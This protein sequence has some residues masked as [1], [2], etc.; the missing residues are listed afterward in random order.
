VLLG[1]TDSM[2]QITHTGG[3]V[4]SFIAG[5]S[6]RP[7]GRRRVVATVMLV[8]SALALA[9]CGDSSK[10]TD[11]PDA[12]S[13][14]VN[15][16]TAKTAVE[17]AYEGTYSSPPTTPTAPPADKNLWVISCGQ[18]AVGC[19]TPSDAAAEAAEAVGWDVTVYDGKLGADNAY[20]TGVRQ[21]V[22]AKADAIIIAAFDCAYAKAP[23]QE[24][25]DA[26]ILVVSLLAYDCDDPRVGG[27]DPL[28]TGS[29]IPNE[30]ETTVADYSIA[31]GKMKADWVIAQ[32][33]GDTTALSLNNTGVLL[34]QDIAK[35]FD[36]EIKACA[37]CKLVSMPFTLADIAGGALPGKVGQALLKDPDVNAAMVP[38]DALMALGVAQAFVR[39]GKN[40]KIATIGGEGYKPNL[41]LIES[42]GGQD[43]AV[44]ES[45]AWFGYAAVD[46]LIRLFNGEPL[47]PA[48]IGSQ[49][50]DA[51]H[52][53][54]TDEQGII[55]PV[56]FKAAYLKAWGK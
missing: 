29:V 34:G 56:D 20:S 10:A 54:P 5:P 11:G 30:N 12:A 50:V 28:F 2:P 6:A 35:G 33:D 51:D 42:N 41:D 37:S 22:A 24:A 26:G 8:L 17:A 3:I 45:T 36:D 47:E 13:G 23:L 15:L 1:P 16:E 9:G 39:S 44:Y 19:S 38:Y 14:S 7:N 18:V 21:A 48:G 55:A 52:V 31:Q 27:G 43:A 40:D 49:L 53:P 4:S 32:T 46:S 25:K